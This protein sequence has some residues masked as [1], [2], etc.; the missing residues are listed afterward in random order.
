MKDAFADDLQILV[1]K[2]IAHKPSFRAEANEQLK[3][4]Y[5]HKLYNQSYAAITH[6]VLQTSD[7]TETFTQF[8]GQL[9]L[10]FGS[11]SRSGKVSSWTAAIET[12]ASTISQVSQEPKLLKNSSQRQNRIDQQA[13]KISSLEAQNQKLGQLL[14]PKFLVET[15]TKAVAINLNINVGNKPQQSEASGYTGRPCLG[16]PRPSKLAPGIDGSL[17]PELSC[18]NCK[19]TGHLKENCIKLNRRLA[20]ENKQPDQLPKKLEN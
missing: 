19:D 1:R 8:W 16:K 7:P 10:T 18:W 9:A 15:I 20:F 3:H 5:A 6:S 13:A 17:D 4:Q 2:I 12:T 14:E 11:H